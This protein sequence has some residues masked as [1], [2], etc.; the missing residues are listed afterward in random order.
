MA[1]VFVSNKLAKY[2]TAS[3]ISHFCTAEK[4][5][6]M[7]LEHGNQQTPTSQNT[8]TGAGAVVIAKN[9]SMPKITYATIGKVIDMGVKDMANMGAAMAPAA[10][11]TIYQHFLD[12]NRTADYYDLIITGDLRSIRK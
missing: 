1:S 8:V 3:S 2:T 11:D 10:F 4:Q 7:P 9:E 6:R 12:T 5:F